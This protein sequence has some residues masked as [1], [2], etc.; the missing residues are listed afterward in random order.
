[1]KFCP[2]KTIIGDYGKVD[3]EE[4]EIAEVSK[5]CNEESPHQSTEPQ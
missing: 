4:K 1:V 3:G 5:T 2:L